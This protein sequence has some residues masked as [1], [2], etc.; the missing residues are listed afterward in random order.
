M[1]HSTRNIVEHQRKPLVRGIH[2]MRISKFNTSLASENQWFPLPNMVSVNQHFDDTCLSD[3]VGTLLDELKKPDVLRQLYKIQE[4]DTIAIGCGSRGIS[5]SVPLLRSLVSFLKQKGALPFLFP[6][7]GSHGGSSEIGQREILEGYGITENNIGAPLQCSMET[8]PIG[9]TEDGR[10]TYLDKHA[11]EANHIIAINRIKAHTAFQGPYE[12][13]I[14]KMLVIGMGKAKGAQTVH[15][16]GFD[17][18]ADNIQIFGK[19][20][21]NKAPI[22][23]GIG[24]LENAYEH[25][26]HIAV[27]P[28]TKIL[29]EEPKLLKIAKSQMGR[30]NF[31]AC[32]VLI[33][34]RLGKD[35]SGE[36]MDPNV[37]GRFPTELC[38]P[39]FSAQKLAVL[40]ITQ[41]SHGNCYGVGL[42]DIT[43]QDMID[44]SDLQSMYINAI[45]NTVLHGVKIPL[46]CK[47][48]MEAIQTA[49]ATCVGIDKKN[50]KIIRIANTRD[51]STLM[52]SEA[53]LHEA[54][55][56]V[57]IT[58]T[59]KPEP[60]QFTERGNLF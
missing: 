21:L 5:N 55:T 16:Q 27:L 10:Q 43:T 48:H 58:I 56:N 3:P 42:A 17:A 35:I 31:P 36:G 23:L 6:A 20:I 34:D 49:I 38:K 46:M 54:E 22:L 29:E 7:M 9:L 28:P 37:T 4:G 2:I 24:L 15:E 11:Y 44:H 41:N 33:V 53:M 30:I 50:P 47:S 32:D 18:M 14:L 19:T 39:T 52:I 26:S 51:L 13:G 45:T 1:Q 8:V 57:N 12:S 25:T 40:D 60:L 59:T